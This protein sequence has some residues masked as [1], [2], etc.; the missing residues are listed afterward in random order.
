[1]AKIYSEKLPAIDR[2]RIEKIEMFDEFE[3]WQLLQ[4]HYCLVLAQKGPEGG[5][6]L[7]I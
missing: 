7:T 4:S 6:K 3:E 5:V 1:M 2:I